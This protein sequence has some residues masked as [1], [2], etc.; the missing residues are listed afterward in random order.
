M[1]Y[2]SDKA[3][4]SPMDCYGLHSF[5]YPLSTHASSA[6]SKYPFAHPHQTLRYLEP[7][8]I[9]CMFNMFGWRLNTFENSKQPLPTISIPSPAIDV[10]A[11]M[12]GCFIEDWTDWTL[13]NVDDEVKCYFNNTSAITMHATP[14]RNHQIPWSSDPIII[15]IF[16]W[17]YDVYYTLYCYYNFDCSYFSEIMCVCVLFFIMFMHYHYHEYSSFYIYI[18]IFCCIMYMFNMFRYNVLSC[19]LYKNRIIW[20]HDQVNTHE[21]KTYYRHHAETKPNPIYSTY[22]S[23]INRSSPSNLVD[24][25]LLRVI[26]QY[27]YHDYLVD[28]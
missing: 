22:H 10:S 2:C 16:L 25:H 28:Y 24:I 19:C 18:C 7:L 3:M 23:K 27:H 4:K 13:T 11:S 14:T 21:T 26:F 8:V 17:P 6:S 1:P 5:T 9:R 12:I 15:P 20:I